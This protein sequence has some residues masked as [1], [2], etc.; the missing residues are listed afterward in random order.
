M[1]L[2]ANVNTDLTTFTSD[3]AVLSTSTMATGGATGLA[4]TISAFGLWTSTSAAGAGRAA[5]YPEA[6]GLKLISGTSTVF[7][8]TDVI[9]SATAN[10]TTLANLRFF[11]TGLFGTGGAG[12]SLT[13]NSFQIDQI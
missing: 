12:S 4:F 2:D 5:F 10:V 9:L 11:V 7:A 13:I 6:G 3:V 8:A 1:Y